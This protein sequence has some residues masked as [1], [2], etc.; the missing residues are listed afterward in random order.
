M[1]TLIQTPPDNYQIPEIVLP[2]DDKILDAYSRAVIG[3]AEKLSPSVVNVE[4]VHKI[5][6]GSSRLNAGREA[7]GCGSGFIFT[8]DGFILTNS[9]VVSNASSI[10]VTLFDGRKLPARVIG[11]DPYT[12]LAVIKADASGLTPVSF[13]D[14]KSIKAGQLVIAIGNPYGFQCTI[15]TGVISALGRS[16]RTDSGRLVDGI[17]QTDAALNPGNSGGPLVTSRGDVIGVNTAI[18]YPAQGICFAIPSH[19]A[20]Y[21][22]EKLIK[23]GRI[24]RSCI[25][26][27]GFDLTADSHLIKSWDLSVDKG[28]LVI[29]VGDNSPAE[30]C[31]LVRGDVIVAFG[32][33]EIAGG[34]DLHKILTEDKIDQDLTLKVM[35]GSE[36]VSLRV[37]PAELMVEGVSEQLTVER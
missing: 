19:I 36:K 10:D 12:D 34:D 30:K 18:I 6:R 25:G 14:S 4:V 28:V 31:G 7:H 33:Q 3:A 29:R 35:R 17:I 22:A 11:D 5:N 16:L 32:D 8:P 20:R 2:S 1:E 23:D 37:R 21:V 24:R 13:G 27:A 9:H 15:T 26:V